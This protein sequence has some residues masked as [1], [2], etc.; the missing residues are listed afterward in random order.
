MVLLAT[1]MAG[2]ATTLHVGASVALHFI[3]SV[4]PYK[5]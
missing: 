1:V 5:T 3:V 2:I 4:I